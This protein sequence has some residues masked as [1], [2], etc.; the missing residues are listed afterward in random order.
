MKRIGFIALFCLI[1]DQLSKIIIVNLF[2]VHRG[3]TI[4]PSFF[5]LMYVQNTG[6][7]W[8]ILD[9]NRLFLIITSIL[10]LIV[11]YLFFIKKQ[12]LKKI[13]H[14]IYGILIGGIL[15]NLFDRIFRGFVVDYLSF[16][17]FGY[18]F[19]IFNLADIFI[20]CSVFIILILTLR[21][22]KQDDSTSERK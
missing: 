22:V 5:S 8:S 13:E 16:N 15:G 3:I 18:P 1:L 11:I 12:E 21:G 20:V 7:A 9:G 19:P 17:I 2:S 10:A 4:I 14:V 6:A